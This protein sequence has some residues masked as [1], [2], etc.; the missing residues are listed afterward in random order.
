MDN[1]KLK[2]MKKIEYREVE[3]VPITW[4]LYTLN[5]ICAFVISENE[6]IKKSQL[7][8]LRK[9]INQV[10]IDK[11]YN[12]QERIDRMTFIIKGLEAKLDLNY[13]DRHIVLCHI[14]GNASGKNFIE[15]ESIYREL[16]NHEVE[17]INKLISETLKSSYLENGVDN[18]LSQ[19]TAFKTTDAIDKVKLIPLVEEAIAQL[20]MKL[21]SA[22]VQ[23]SK[24]EFFSLKD[25]IFQE[26]ITE[27]Y[28]ELK[29]PSHMLITGMQGLNEMLGGGFERGRLYLF[30]GL[31][32]E[33]KSTTMLNIAYQLKKYN[34]NYVL[35]DKTKTPCIVFLT[36]ENSLKETVERLFNI[37]TRPESLVDYTL[38]EV[39]DLMRTEGQLFLSDS[40]AIDIVIKYAPSD[41]NDTNYLYTLY[42]ELEDNGYECI[43]MIQDYLKRIK[44]A[45]NHSTELRLEL[46]YIC[47]EFKTFGEEKQIPVISASQLNRAAAKHIDESRSKKNS[48]L[49]KLF[50]RDN[51][52]ESVN[53][54]E[55]TDALF[56]LA[57]EI[58][59][60]GN[61]Y[62]GMQL[63]K[64]RFKGTSRNH[65]Y[66][67]YVPGN[68][69]KLL[70]DEG[71]AEPMY[72]ETLNPNVERA[73]A[74]ANGGLTASFCSNTPVLNNNSDGLKL[75][76][77][78]STLF[79]DKTSG[80]SNFFEATFIPN[81]IMR[82]KK[83]LFRFG[84]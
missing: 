30:L 38:E 79:E 25:G 44:S 21:R 83:Q 77:S 62:L 47:N 80:A 33:G 2:Y 60:E 50:G 74:F 82:R 14:N 28:N 11:S 43:C 64:K 19:L 9:L 57:P 51:I 6:S 78:S 18:L 36:M 4:D 45:N 13:Q 53:I 15:D 27:I 29:S 1:R 54:L 68:S 69:I 73:M 20:Q 75:L 24:E 67:P 39:M 8:Q 55:N 35:K 84:K 81:N 16:N 46:G 42:D 41:L 12:D 32:G 17:F 48:D 52:G 66:Q 34:K 71:L 7:F 26:K 5:I 63:A 3:K 61:K 58:D 49:V 40:S 23:N 37:S 31:P 65:C 70:E 22:R 10:D 59:H 72:K 76:N 56:F